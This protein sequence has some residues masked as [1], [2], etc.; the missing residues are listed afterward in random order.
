MFNGREKKEAK[1]DKKKKLSDLRNIEQAEDLKEA[2]HNN[3]SLKNVSQNT[4]IFVIHPIA[5]SEK[6]K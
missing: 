2:K 6:G 5:Q 1:K 4:E 3:F